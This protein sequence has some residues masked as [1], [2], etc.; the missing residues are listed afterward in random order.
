MLEII[1]HSVVVE[2]AGPHVEQGLIDFIVKVPVLDPRL[3]SPIHVS[4]L[5]E[6][7]VKKDAA[8]KGLA[9]RQ[10]STCDD[11]AVFHC[12]CEP[13]HSRFVRVNLPSLA[14]VHS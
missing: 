3:G 6:A 12:G 11:V 2:L 9:L 5:V 1:L 8:S 14:P 13:C 10:A 4:Q 7:V